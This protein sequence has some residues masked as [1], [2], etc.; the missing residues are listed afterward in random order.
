[1]CVVSLPYQDQG[2]AS[3]H[4][5][6]AFHR[7]NDVP[8]LDLALSHLPLVHLRHGRRHLLKVL[9]LLNLMLVLVLVLHLRGRRRACDGCRRSLRR[10]WSLLRHWRCLLW[11]LRLNLRL[12]HLRCCKI[13]VVIALTSTLWR[14]LDLGVG[15]TLHDC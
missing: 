5:R 15:V 4:A 12:G 13:A 7:I 9:V 3:N 6:H 1:M 11:L 10:D 14:I 8:L 2:T